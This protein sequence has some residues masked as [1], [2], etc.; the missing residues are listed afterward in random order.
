MID[1]GEALRGGG[2]VVA[3]RQGELVR[4]LRFCELIL[5]D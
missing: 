2:V 1:V 4:L 3:V 5:R